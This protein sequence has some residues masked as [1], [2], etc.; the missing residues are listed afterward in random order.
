MFYVYM[1]VNEN[2][3]LNVGVTNNP[4]RRLSEHNTSR[5]S[6]HTTKG[7]F[8]TVFLEE[9]KTLTSA[10][11]REIQ[12]KKWRRSKK[13]RLIERYKNGLPTKP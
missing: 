3:Y 8:R 1:V 13:E 5:G 9:H 6:M 2:D 10:R 11:R 12:I 4:D 7:I